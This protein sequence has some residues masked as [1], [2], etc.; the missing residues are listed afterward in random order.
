MLSEREI[1]KVYFITLKFGKRDGIVVI[2][3]LI[4]RSVEWRFKSIVIKYEAK[5][6]V[7]D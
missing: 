3:E 7:N 1:G 2:V 4:P 6:R 5:S